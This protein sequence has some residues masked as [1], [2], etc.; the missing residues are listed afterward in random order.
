MPIEGELF[1]LIDIATELKVS[2]KTLRRYMKTYSNIPIKRLGRFYFT[3]KDDLKKW[4]ESL[5][6]VCTAKKKK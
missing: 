1:K 3:T 5:P 4:K 6:N 2:V